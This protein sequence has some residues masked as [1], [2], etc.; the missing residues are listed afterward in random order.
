MSQFTQQRNKSC[1]PWLLPWSNNELSIIWCHQSAAKSTVT[2]GETVFYEPLSDILEDFEKGCTH[3]PS[4]I[5]HEYNDECKQ[6]K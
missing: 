4:D 2:E 5:I 6:K 1:T 3:R